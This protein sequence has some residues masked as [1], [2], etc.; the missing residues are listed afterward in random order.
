MAEKP[1]W[2]Q[3]VWR[4]VREEAAAGHQVYVVCPRVGGDQAKG[5]PDADLVD[6]DDPDMGAD[7]DDASARR[8]PACDARPCAAACGPNRPT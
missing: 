2:L 7:A 6:L 4:R 8:P 1:G 5:D 3:Q